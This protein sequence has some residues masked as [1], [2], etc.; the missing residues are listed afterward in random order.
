[1]RSRVTFDP[2]VVEGIRRQVTRYQPVRIGIRPFGTKGSQVQILSPRPSNA[3][4]FF[5]KAGVPGRLRFPDEMQPAP[6]K[7]QTIAGSPAVAAPRVFGNL[8]QHWVS[9]VA[10]DRGTHDNIC[11]SQGVGGPPKRSDCKAEEQRDLCRD[12]RPN[13]ESR[14]RPRAFDAPAGLPHGGRGRH[15]LNARRATATASASGVVGRPMRRRR[16]PLASSSSPLTM[17]RS[18]LKNRSA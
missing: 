17:P 18:E 15:E 5:A 11:R 13:G 8:L 7:H 3:P 2:S 9:R 1:M 6:L 16:S 4:E 12:R 10:P 14:R